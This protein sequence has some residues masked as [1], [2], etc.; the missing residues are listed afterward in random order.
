MSPDRIPLFIALVWWSSELFLFLRNYGLL[1]NAGGNMIHKSKPNSA[2]LIL[3][4]I[5]CGEILL[6]PSYWLRPWPIRRLPTALA[7]AEICSLFVFGHACTLNLNLV[8]PLFLWSWFVEYARDC[9]NSCTGSKNISKVR[10]NCRVLI[11]E[12]TTSQIKH[13][14]N[15]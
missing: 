11:P 14:T 4:I 13:G 8:L 3:F 6:P 12:N 7:A 9:Q 1:N 15:F 10:I 5:Q 2:A